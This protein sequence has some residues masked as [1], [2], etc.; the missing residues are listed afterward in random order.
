MIEGIM[1]KHSNDGT[2]RKE[3]AYPYVTFPK[4]LNLAATVK[5]CGGNRAPVS[6]KLLAKTLGV[7]EDAPSFMQGVAS[8]RVFG[9]IVGRGAYTLTEASQRYFFPTNDT[10]K[11]LAQL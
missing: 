11:A 10:D 2:S 3:P 1:A 8:A 7:G 5:D 9:M 4:C 6:R